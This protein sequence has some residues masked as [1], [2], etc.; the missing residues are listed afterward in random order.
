MGKL[1]ESRA[2]HL[3]A[4]MREHPVVLPGAFNALTARAIERAGF[5]A[6]YLSGAA[7][8]NSQLGVPDV[9]LTTLSEAAWHATRCAT[10]TTLPIIADA[11]TG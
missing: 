6:I 4:L 3:R 1:T 10:V 11:D 9:G 8:A 2:A 7:L 5:E